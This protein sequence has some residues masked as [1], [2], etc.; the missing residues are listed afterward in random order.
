MSYLSVETMT[1]PSPTAARRQNPVYGRYFADP[2]VF[3]HEG[4]YYAIGT[5][6]M[7]ARD[8]RVFP[9]LKSTDFMHWT[10][11][12]GALNPVEGLGN[13]YWAPEI[14]FRDGRFAMVYSVG[15]GDNGHQLRVAY[16]DR[17]EGP[18]QDQG[19]PLLDPES[20][21][22]SIDGHPFQDTDGRWYLFY[23]RDFLDTDRP[24]T[25]LVVTPWDDVTRI[26]T[27]FTVVGRARHE[28]QRY[29]ARRPMYGGIYDWHTLEGPCVVR[30]EGRY[31]CLF[32]GGNW[33][34]A[35]YG[36]DYVVADKVMG[37]YR[38]DNPGDVPRILRSVPD[39]LVGPGHNSVV[40]GPDGQTLYIAY[41]AWKEG[42]RRFCLDP[43]SWTLDG[44]RCSAIY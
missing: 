11:T 8:G 10:P 33:Q 6:P 17:P 27:D 21:A 2:F 38:D 41:H 37:P 4:V 36:V 13:D 40:C 7:D 16:S 25:A 30:H 1:A 44:P 5:G 31:Y 43:L 28:W 34:N 29:Q 12:G 32:S 19:T 3:L 18:Y 39:R 9:M 23:A 26:G 42:E 35:T 22:F 14:A 20:S 24:G 15:A